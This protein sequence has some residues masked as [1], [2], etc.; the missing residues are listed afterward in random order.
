MF[1]EEISE[2]VFAFCCKRLLQKFLHEKNEQFVKYICAL[3]EF[4]IKYINYIKNIFTKLTTLEVLI[5][6]G[7]FKS[8]LVLIS[9]KKRMWKD[10]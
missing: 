5:K 4:L 8:F 7:A 3:F 10:K 9:G 6:N 2:I 1:R